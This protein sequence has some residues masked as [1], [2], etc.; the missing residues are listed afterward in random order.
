MFWDMVCFIL[1][2]YS[3][4]PK[5]TKAGSSFPLFFQCICSIT[6]LCPALCDRMNCSTPGFPV[7][8]CLPE[9]AQTDVHWLSDAIQPSHPLSPSS[10]PHYNL[11]QHQGLFQW[12]S[13]SH[14]VAKVLE[15]Q[16]QHQSF[17]WNFIRQT[18]P[19]PNCHGD[20][21]RSVTFWNGLIASTFI[22]FLNI[23]HSLINN[24]VF[25][26]LLNFLRLCI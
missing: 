2:S 14:Q 5:L 18:K 16:F 25:F 19:N 26:W 7:L 24:S 22:I 20:K 6:K 15:L 21:H 10:P 1:I 11:S 13:C 3:P 17:Q 23:R 9:F 4:V 12:V 8:H